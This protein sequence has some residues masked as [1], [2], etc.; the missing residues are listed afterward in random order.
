MAKKDSEAQFMDVDRLRI[1]IY[2]YL[3]LGWMQH[4]FALN[5]F[6][7]SSREQIAT[8]LGLGITRIRWSPEKSDPE[9]E[10]AHASASPAAAPVAAAATTAAADEPAIAPPPPA[11]PTADATEAPEAADPGAPTAT[12]GAAPAQ[13][14]RSRL[15]TQHEH[16]E[17]CERQFAHAGRSYRQVVELVRAKPE[18][19][20]SHA[21]QVVGN[22][23]GR[24]FEH[25][26]LAIRLLSEN[27]GEKSSLHSINVTVI[28]LLLGKAMNLDAADLADLGTGALLHDIG[29]IA[30][31]E[32]LRWKDEQFSSAERHVF[33]EH[34]IHGAGFVRAMKLPE[35]VQAIVAQHHEYADGH[36]YPRK[37]VGDAIAPLARVV[38]L[39]NHYDNLCNPGN[40]TQAVTPHEALSQI[41]AQ[42]KRQFDPAVLTMFIR[43]MGVYP[44][45]SLIELTDG[46]HAL[47]VSVNSSRPL[48][49]HIIIHDPRTPRHEALVEDLEHLPELGIRRSLKP[50]QLPKAAFDYL[51]PRQ[52]ICY[53][54]ERARSA[55]D[56][57]DAP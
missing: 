42:M 31:P 25:E 44:P 20:R 39:V 50:L 28:S 45:G 48:K 14:P 2:V 30:L 11:D 35:R 56:T 7:I 36:G 23:V 10:P 26:E 21:E 17:I 40:P 3:D 29:K 54:F 33:E 13:A 4:P 57:E 32:R 15:A 1:G 38:A 52:R 47:V 43:M 18:E 37:L 55:G 51:S 16:L 5:S 12:E 53:F 46:R 49:P 41:F 34:V 19:A 8:I 27:A 22:M 24:L 9:P 6:K